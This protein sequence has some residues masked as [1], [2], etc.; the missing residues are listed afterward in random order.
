[1]IE[2]DLAMLQFYDPDVAFARRTQVVRQPLLSGRR[3]STNHTIRNTYVTNVVDKAKIEIAAVSNVNVYVLCLCFCGTMLVVQVFRHMTFSLVQGC[4]QTR[5][6][7]SSQVVCRNK[8]LL[9][10]MLS[11]NGG[12]NN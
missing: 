1:M 7:M 11:H 5:R 8:S 12:T 6:T 10:S 4:N 2:E 3:S 9:G